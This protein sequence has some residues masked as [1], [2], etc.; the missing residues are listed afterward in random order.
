[1]CSALPAREKLKS[2]E[3]T[4]VAGASSSESLATT[5]N[6]LLIIAATTYDYRIR[7]FAGSYFFFFDDFFFFFFFLITRYLHL[8][9]RM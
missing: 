1:M 2:T 5:R 4:S 3:S 7:A 9:V 8:D 6:G